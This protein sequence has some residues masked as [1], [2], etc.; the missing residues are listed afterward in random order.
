MPGDIGERNTSGAA[1]ASSGVHVRA[2]AVSHDRMTR[3]VSGLE[4]VVADLAAAREGVRTT[5]TRDRPAFAQSRSTRRLARIAV[6][7][8]VP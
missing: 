3:L 4:A 8:S 2:A 6:L 7:P 5:R 1:K